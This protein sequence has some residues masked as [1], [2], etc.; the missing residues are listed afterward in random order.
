MTEAGEGK[1]DGSV[2]PW[3][4]KKGP[5]LWRIQR[6]LVDAPSGHMQGLRA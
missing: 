2:C 6:S 1:Q 3:Q 5:G 4:Q